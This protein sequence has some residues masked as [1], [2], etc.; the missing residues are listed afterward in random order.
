MSTSLAVWWG[1]RVLVVDFFSRDNH[2]LALSFESCSFQ[3][4][5]K[6]TVEPIGLIFVLT[7]CSLNYI[8]AV[9][10]AEICGHGEPS[11]TGGGERR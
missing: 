5:V 4:I 7:I 1:V 11:G 3:F 6:L 9:Q 2:R 8:Y 10:Y